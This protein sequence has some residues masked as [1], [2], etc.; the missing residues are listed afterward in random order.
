MSASVGGAVCVF[1]KCPIPGQSKTRIAPLLGEDGSASLATAMISDILVSLT[2]CVPL[3]ETLKILVYAPGSSEGEAHMKSILQSLNLSSTSINEGSYRG[4]FDG[5]V[6]LPMASG[7]ST[8]DL[9]S[10]ALGSKLEDALDKTR[11]LLEKV[12]PQQSNE[13]VLFLGMDA[14]EVPLEE[15]VY[16]LQTSSRRNKAHMCPADD[17]GY[18][19]LSVPRNAPSSRIFRGVRWSNKLTAVSQL[20]ALSDCNVDISI[21]KMMSDVDEPDD[22]IRLAQRLIC[23]RDSN[24]VK[25]TDDVLES[26]SFSISSSIRDTDA[27]TDCQYT[28]KALLDLNVITKSSDGVNLK[29][30]ENALEII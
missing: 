5:W 16:G 29:T 28:M 23:S 2:S 25:G 26:L 21:G 1:A 17:G 24:Q 7:A 12:T 30:S 22:V 20:K 6:L 10:S 3:K 9:T 19:L 27:T 4:V 8:A 14:P 13:A 11:Q 18:G 15:V